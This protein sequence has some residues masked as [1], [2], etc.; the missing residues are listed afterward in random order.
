LWKRLYPEIIGP[1][2]PPEGGYKGEIKY[3][4]YHIIYIKGS[5][6]PPLGDLGGFGGLFGSFLII[7]S[8]HYSNHENRQYK[9]N[10]RL[11][12]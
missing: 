8:L 5:L 6:S 10:K 7:L 3:E 9:K 12:A 2:T 4:K 1:P 11:P